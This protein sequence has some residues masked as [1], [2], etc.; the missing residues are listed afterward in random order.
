MQICRRSHLENLG[1]CL[2]DAGVLVN[3]YL[4]SVDESNF[5][6]GSVTEWLEYV[7]EVLH[8]TV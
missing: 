5:S 7:G 2:D 1:E 6:L 3:I 4:Y 8:V